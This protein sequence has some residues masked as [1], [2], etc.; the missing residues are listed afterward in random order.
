MLFL[1]VVIAGLLAFVGFGVGVAAIQ[2]IFPNSPTGQD[3]PAMVKLVYYC[4]PLIVGV[5]LCSL[6]FARFV[7]PLQKKKALEDE[8]KAEE[9]RKMRVKA[10]DDLWAK[11]DLA[12]EY[13]KYSRAIS[14]AEGCWDETDRQSMY[15]K[16]AEAGV[17][18]ALHRLHGQISDKKYVSFCKK[19]AQRGSSEAMVLG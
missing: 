13:G 18:V 17:A 11:F 4:V 6:Y 10:V 2:K 9:D 8:K 19:S 5:T 3:L 16:L 15:L 1:H 12:F 7:E 14:I